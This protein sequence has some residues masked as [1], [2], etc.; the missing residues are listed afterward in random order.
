MRCARSEQSVRL[1]TLSVDCRVSNRNQGHFVSR[2]ETNERN[3]GSSRSSNSSLKAFWEQTYTDLTQFKIVFR[4]LAQLQVASIEPI[5]LVL[6]ATVGANSLGNIAIDNISFR[7]G[8]CP[9]EWRAKH[10]PAHGIH[11]YNVVAADAAATA[12]AVNVI[13]I[14]TI[15]LRLSD[16]P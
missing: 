6:E 10:F 5:Q 7:P 16:I 9:S 4:Y 3:V 14:L 12:T 8:T 15:N 11:R 2:R 13:N 1:T